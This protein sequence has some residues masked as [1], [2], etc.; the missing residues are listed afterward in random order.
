[1]GPAFRSFAEAE[2]VLGLHDIG[3]PR[4]LPGGALPIALG[5]KF[6]APDLMQEGID[7]LELLRK[8]VAFV[9]DDS[10]F[11]KR[12]TDFIEFQANFL[13]SGETDAESVKKAVE[14]MKR[15]I[16]E[17]QDA[18]T[19]LPLRTVLHDVCQLVPIAATLGVA[20]GSGVDVPLAATAAVCWFAGLCIDEWLTEEPQRN[21]DP[22]AFIL[23]ARQH[24]AMAFAKRQ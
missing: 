21:N 20:L 22:S 9:T 12:R 5:W 24:F 7:E 17:V 1:M 6:I 18:A 14:E 3:M 13:R 23:D 4:P 19:R 10:Q 8:T 16:S 2:T 15:L 11:R